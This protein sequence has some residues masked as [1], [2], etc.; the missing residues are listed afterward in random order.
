MILNLTTFKV[1]THIIFLHIKHLNYYFG[2]H[3]V[4][5]RFNCF[6]MI[7][8]FP[9]YGISQKILCISILMFNLSFPTENF[10]KEIKL[11]FFIS[12]PSLSSKGKKK[13]L[14]W[15]IFRKITRH[16]INTIN[17]FQKFLH[18]FIKFNINGKIS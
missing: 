10:S 14:T 8:F 11:L 3:Y 6:I 15:Y 18:Y 13:N 4:F 5:K 7:L 9:W 2:I 16:T 12:F 1:T 17:S